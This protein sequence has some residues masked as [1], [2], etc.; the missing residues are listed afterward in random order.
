MRHRAWIAGVIVL[1]SSA[2]IAAEH[3]LTWVALG[4]A[5]R[6]EVLDLTTGSILTSFEMGAE[7]TQLSLTPDL[8]YIYVSCRSDGQTHVLRPISGNTVKRLPYIHPV[9]TATDSQHYYAPG[10]GGVFRYEVD[11]YLSEQLAYLPDTQNSYAYAVS[12]DAR[13]FVYI[14]RFVD[15][16]DQ[17]ITNPPLY[18]RIAVCNLE[19]ATGQYVDLGAEPL[20]VA[21]SPEGGYAVVGCSGGV[22]SLIDLAA[23]KVVYTDD[24]LGAPVRFVSFSPDGSEVFF[25]VG[26]TIFSALVSY[27]L[28]DAFVSPDYHAFRL[29]TDGDSAGDV[30][31]GALALDGSLVVV[32]GAGTLTLIDL[33]EMKVNLRFPL[34]HRANDLVLALVDEAKL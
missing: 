9:F 25:S 5:E 6:V 29:T 1:I 33:K 24:A 22:Y 8:T 20:S 19:E 14:Q 7:P 4:E 16:R 34:G 10:L 31:H 3:L 27:L 30:T 21:V 17:N 32:D 23:A 15:W 12:A 28:S 11:G 26:S 2:S 18:D 13:W